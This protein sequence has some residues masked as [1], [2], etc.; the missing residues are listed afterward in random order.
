[1]LISI[2]AENVF[3]KNSASIYDKRKKKPLQKVNI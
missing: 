3:E 1:M 2:D